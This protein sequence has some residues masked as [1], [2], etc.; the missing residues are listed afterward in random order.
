[1]TGPWLVR[2]GSKRGAGEYVHPD[3]FLY[4]D[5]SPG[6]ETTTP[7]QR[8][9]RRFTTGFLADRYARAFGGRVVRLRERGR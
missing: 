8:E 7:H 9:A 5:G 3:A 6:D 4:V 1:M 2:L